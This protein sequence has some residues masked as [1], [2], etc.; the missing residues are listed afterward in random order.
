MY[1]T[2][3]PLSDLSEEDAAKVY[4]HAVNLMKRSDPYVF[5]KMIICAGTGGSIGAASGVL[6]KDIVFSMEGLN[7]YSLTL[8]AIC[9]AAGGSIGGVIASIRLRKKLD[10]YFTKARE[11]LSL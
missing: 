5:F 10:P 3:E 11:E 9:A 1:S 4:R 2:I 6:L 8:I 7:V